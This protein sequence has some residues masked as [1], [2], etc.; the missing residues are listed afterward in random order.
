MT[1]FGS[2]ESERLLSALFLNRYGGEAWK[3]L[4]PLLAALG[5][6]EL[7]F[8]L[9]EQVRKHE[10]PS[11]TDFEDGLPTVY[12]YFVPDA[13]WGSEHPPPIDPLDLG[14]VRSMDGFGL[15]FGCPL[16]LA[17]A[18][19]IV[20]AGKIAYPSGNA[21]SYRVFDGFYWLSV[22]YVPSYFV[23]LLVVYLPRRRDQ[24]NLFVFVANQTAMLIGDG[25]A[26]HAELSKAAKH[27]S[28]AIPSADDFKTICGQIDPASSAPLLKRTQP[29]EYASWIEFL[30]ERKARSERAIDLLLRYML[31]LESEHVRL[32][33]EIKDC[34]LF[35]MLDGV[36]RHSFSNKDMSFL[37]SAL[38]SYYN[39]TRELAAYSDKHMRGVAW[40]KRRQ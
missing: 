19:E 28:T 30:L 20:V 1:M 2:R 9:L 21:L 13:G 40:S 35:M 5:R 26:V 22:S 34:V 25:Q 14:F 27:T 4:E 10:Y 36:A 37:A 11:Y 31:Y 17:R 33:T 8:D 32:V 3:M 24:K 6:T 7:P 29:M 15:N 12:Y 38:F 23:Y 16:R 39:L 18:I